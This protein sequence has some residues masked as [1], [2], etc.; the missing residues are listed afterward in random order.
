MKI[1]VG[2]LDKSIR[3]TVAAL[4]ALLYFTKVISGTVAI[5]LVVLALIFAI[6]SFLNF[7]PIWSIFGINTS[8]KIKIMPETHWIKKTY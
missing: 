2:T 3:L 8:Q 4:I 1:N 5:I 7:C 6:T